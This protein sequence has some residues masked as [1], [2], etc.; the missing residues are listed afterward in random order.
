MKRM[1]E[2]Y[3]GDGFVLLSILLFSCGSTK[4]LTIDQPTV[5]IKKGVWQYSPLTIDGDDSDWTSPVFFRDNKQ[6]FSYSI[7]GDDS[8]F[9]LVLKTADKATHAKILFNGI[10]IGMSGGATGKHKI[11]LQ[12]P[13][14]RQDY[15]AKYSIDYINNNQGHI[16]NADIYELSGD[17]RDN[18]LHY[19]KEE[20]EGIH[21]QLSMN[22][23]KEMVYEVQVPFS[24]LRKS[25]ETATRRD[26]QLN[27][28]IGIAG[29]DKNS[30]LF[31][32]LVSQFGLSN[33][34]GTVQYESK[35]FPNPLSSKKQFISQHD[36]A[37]RINNV[38]TSVLNKS[39]KERCR[40]V[41]QMRD[42]Q[43]P[44]DVEQLPT[45]RVFSYSSHFFSLTNEAG[46]YRP[47][48]FNYA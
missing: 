41:V 27:C 24:T 14:S 26:K 33:T 43:T 47:F 13:L 7:R 18:G 37:K 17:Y 25:S 2:R 32:S 19:R 48:F 36:R 1:K 46:F 44:P 38:W 9:Y 16:S 11:V 20:N 4:K 3:Y 10:S 6:A 40:A 30:I 23:R 34:T 8:N 5:L 12:C 35:F 29:F 22:S 45:K 42:M 15:S 39:I 31:T 28:R 21:V